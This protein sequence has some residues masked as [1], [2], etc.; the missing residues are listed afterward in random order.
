M[1]IHIPHV[2]CM[3]CHRDMTLLEGTTT[4]ICPL[5]EREIKIE[6]VDV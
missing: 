2:V 6:V 5:C 4:R 1:T 3:D